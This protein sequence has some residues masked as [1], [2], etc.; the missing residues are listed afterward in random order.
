MTRKKVSIDGK[1]YYIH[2]IFTNY[3]ASK[4]GEI[5]N[6]KTG[7]ILKKN[8][9]DM[10]YYQFKVNDKKLIKP[11]N[12]YI[13]RFEW[14][15]VRGVIPEGFV[16]DHIDSVRTN[17]KIYNLQLLTLVENI[18]K[19]NSKPILSFNIKN[20]EQKKYESITSASLELDISFSI[21]SNIC[22]KVKYYKTVI[23]KKDGDRY[24]FE[25]LEKN[26]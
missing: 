3:A 12:Y 7:R 1:K 6:V 24:K 14:E 4:D 22:R 21:I 15:C 9:T 18:R 26:V 5:L 2:P 17:N 10:G 25:F 19:G 8:L 11:K 23:S 13:H 16:I 20:N